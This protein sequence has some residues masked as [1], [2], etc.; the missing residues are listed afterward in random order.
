MLMLALLVG[1]CMKSLS[2]YG[3]MV[4]TFSTDIHGPQRMYKTLVGDLSRS[5]SC[6]HEVVI[7]VF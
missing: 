7:L 3:W 4:M 6:H 5:L 1:Y 2:N